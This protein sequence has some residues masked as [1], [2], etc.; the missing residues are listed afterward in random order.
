MNPVCIPANVEVA[1]LAVSCP[2]TVVEPVMEALPV[3]ERFAPAVTLP[4]ALMFW[5]V[6]M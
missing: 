2:D 1:M 5:E 3:T 6:V 4:P